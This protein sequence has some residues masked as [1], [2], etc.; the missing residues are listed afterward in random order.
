MSSVT[1]QQ[2]GRRS[3]SPVCD[4]I[5]SRLR[6]TVRPRC[7]TS[8]TANNYDGCSMNTITA[9]TGDERSPSATAVDDYRLWTPTMWPGS[10]APAVP[11]LPSSGSGTIALHSPS[12]FP[13]LRSPSRPGFRAGG[14]VRTSK[15]EVRRR[16]GRFREIG[17][18][19]G[20]QTRC[21]LVREV[22]GCDGAVVHPADDGRHQDRCQRLATDLER[23]AERHRLGLE[24][25]PTDDGTTLGDLLSWWET[26]YFRQSPAYAKSCGTFRR[27]L[28][29]SDLSKIPIREVTTAGWSSSSR[30]RRKSWLPRR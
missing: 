27:H 24:P 6:A 26:T 1:N 7:V 3:A 2:K 11:G 29:G 4:A 22:Q 19:F 18:A 13:T 21:S 28:F 10:S 30:R 12:R 17:H 15:V 23:Q 20:F 14:G 8:H 25:L 16:F 5:A 9:T